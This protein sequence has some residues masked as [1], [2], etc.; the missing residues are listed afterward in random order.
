MRFSYRQ[1]SK[2]GLFFGT[3]LAVAGGLTVVF[4]PSHT[5][6][7]GPVFRVPSASAVHKPEKVSPSRAR[8]YGACGIVGGVLFSL[9]SLYV[10]SPRPSNSSMEPN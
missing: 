7:H 10:P 2:A 1:G 8:F 6:Y 5:V 3:A 4:A 9:F